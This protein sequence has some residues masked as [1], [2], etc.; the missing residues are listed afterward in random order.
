[1]TTPPGNGAQCVA[2]ADTDPAPRG[3]LTWRSAAERNKL[4]NVWRLAVFA[5]FAEQP[6]CIQLRLGADQLVQR[7]DRLR[8]RQQ[9]LAGEEHPAARE[10]NAGGA[11]HARNPLARSCAPR[12]PTRGARSSV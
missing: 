2:E 6:R 12:S 3:V 5:M 9:R 11:G 10:Q 7:Q 8:L 4:L 1:M